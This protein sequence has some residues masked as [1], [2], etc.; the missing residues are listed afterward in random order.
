MTYDLLNRY[1]PVVGLVTIMLL[2]IAF[3][4]SIPPAPAGAKMTRAEAISIAHSNCSFIK[5]DYSS[6]LSDCVAWRA[7]L[8]FDECQLMMLKIHCSGWV[9]TSRLETQ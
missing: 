2:V 1:G 6:A 9:D 8:T 5:N 4:W 7:D 3:I